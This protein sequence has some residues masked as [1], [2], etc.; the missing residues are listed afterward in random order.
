MASTSGTIQKL[1]FTRRPIELQVEDADSGR[2]LIERVVVGGRQRRCRLAITRL[3]ARNRPYQTLALR[4]STRVEP[5]R[6]RERVVQRLARQPLI[7][8]TV[9]AL[10][11]QLE[12]TWASDC[13]V[14]VEI[15]RVSR[16]QRSS[17]RSWPIPS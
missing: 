8:G 3:F 13:S 5:V 6:G 15:S 9:R 12:L 11:T 4:L 16:A 17:G 7:R 10:A 2:A 1:R 14:N